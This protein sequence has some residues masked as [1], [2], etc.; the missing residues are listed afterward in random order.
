MVFLE[1]QF[2]TMVQGAPAD[3]PYTIQFS[4]VQRDDLKS[5]AKGK[6]YALAIF[7]TEES[8]SDAVSVQRCTI[9]VIFEFI[10]YIE[11]GETPNEVLN[12]VLM[13]VERRFMEDQ[14]CGGLAINCTVTGS[15]FDP[16]YA[17]DKQ[18]KGAL[19]ANVTYIHR[20]GD[21][22]VIV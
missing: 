4:I 6:K 3:D 15:E 1:N 8:K 16:D 14:T 9:R 13:N 11:Q 10:A 2:T 19:F 12:K 21:P 20:T 18:A 22:R 5:L 17:Y 7:D